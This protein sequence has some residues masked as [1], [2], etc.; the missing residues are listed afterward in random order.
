MSERIRE[1]K[2][3]H[4]R[5]LPDYLCSLKGK[6]L[7]VLAG[8]G[9]GKS[10]IVD[11][12]EFIFTGRISRFHGEGTGNDV[13]TSIDKEH[14]HRVAE[15][16]FE[17]FEDFQLIITTHDEH[18]FG[19]LQSM[20]QARGDQ[21][22]WFFKKIARWTVE[23][24]PES[25][26]FE[27]TWAYIEA[28]LKEEGYRELG[29]SLRVVLEDFLKRVAEKLELKV[30]Y[31][32]D[33]KYTSGDFWSCGIH[34]K[35]R[36]ALVAKCPEEEA[37]IKQ[38]VGRVFGTGDLIN[39]LSHDNPGRLEVTLPQAVD[40]VSGLKALTRRCQDNQLIKGVGS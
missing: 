6:S 24:G 37:N 4:F 39:F 16:F 15:L 40:F 2:F 8:N 36:D 10:G 25:A 13:L 27:S 30:K 11:G 21:G 26:I 9:K 14:R 5:G 23:L 34:D 22:K 33:G 35:I 1:I 17:E 20:A 31:K 18:W 38:E 7:A 12:I 19:I 3:L 29:G 28:N 32:A